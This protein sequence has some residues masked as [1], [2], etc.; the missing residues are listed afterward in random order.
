MKPSII[1]LD[2]PTIA[3]DPKNR[4]TLINTLNRLDY[5]KIIASHDLDMILETCDRVILMAGGR[6][7]CEGETEVILRN[8]DLLEENNLELPL[9]FGGYEKR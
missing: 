4:R 3:L 2:E 1:L 5:I 8:R 6:I 9:C 7:V